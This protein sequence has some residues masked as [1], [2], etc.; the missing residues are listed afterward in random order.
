MSRL[1]ERE[2]EETVSNKRYAVK[3]RRTINGK[4]LMLLKGN[5][6]GNSTQARDLRGRHKKVHI[7]ISKRRREIED[8]V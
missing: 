1:E 6:K 4:V 2:V 3:E 8:L 7:G 5:L